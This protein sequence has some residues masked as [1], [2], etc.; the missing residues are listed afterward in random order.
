MQHIDPLTYPDW[1]ERVLATPHASIFHT[2]NWLRVLQEAYG[3]RPY[4]FACFQEQQLTALLPFMEVKSWVTGVRGVSLPF[5]DYCEP[6]MATQTSP[7]FLAPII[8]VARQQQWKFLAV[9]GGEA[10]FQGVPPYAFYTRHLVGLGGGEE[11]VASRLR[12]NYRVKIRKARQH[13]LT[14][15]ILH[16]PEAMAEYY[17]LH[18]LTR[19][20]HGLP[21][22]PAGF[23]GKIQEHLIAHKLGFISLV[24][25]QGRTVAGAIFFT[26][27]HR[28]MYKFGASDPSYQHLHTNYVLFWHAMQWL[29]RHDYTELCFGRTDQGNTGLMQF[30]DGWGT[31][32]S[33]I[34]YYQYDLRTA[35][36]VQDTHCAGEMSSNICKKMPIPLLQLVGAVLYKHMG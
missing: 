29:C 33:Q 25:H 35:S 32:R 16:S 11:A 1:N 3:Y 27:G 15:T 20:R 13:D 23:F 5:S 7:E 6:I 36:F 18:C 4:Y 22:Q 14:V 12:S 2:T 31:R 10:L 9:R 24:S 21:P 19:K 30:K 28:A 34:T 17:R 8:R 26:F